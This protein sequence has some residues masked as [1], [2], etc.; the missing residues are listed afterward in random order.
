MKAMEDTA[1]I[2]ADL[3]DA[4]RHLAENVTELHQIVKKMAS[5]RNDVMP[6]GVRMAII[7]PSSLVT[8]VSLVWLYEHTAAFT[9][10]LVK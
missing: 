3:K 4:V 8:A 10:S 5:Q 6:L 7:V 9:M 1:K 2:S